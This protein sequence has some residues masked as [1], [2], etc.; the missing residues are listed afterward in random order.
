MV[1]THPSLPIIRYF[2]PINQLSPTLR[3]NVQTCICF[4]VANVLIMFCNFFRM[5]IPYIYPVC[6]KFSNKVPIMLVFGD[7]SRVF[8]K[9]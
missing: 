9:Q 8:Y 7:N 6:I 5:T 2:T 3:Y 4:V 1:M